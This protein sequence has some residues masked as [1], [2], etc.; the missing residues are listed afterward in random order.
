[1]ETAAGRDPLV[2]SGVRFEVLRV[3]S[4]EADN[5]VA[6][7]PSAA[8]R[9]GRAR[10]PSRL[11]RLAPPLPAP[12]TGSLPIAISR[13]HRSPGVPGCGS[14]YY[15][16][17]ISSCTAIPAI[18]KCSVH[19]TKG[20]LSAHREHQFLGRSLPPEVPPQPSTGCSWCPT[21]RNLNL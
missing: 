7:L 13:Q 20:W 19:P 17:D 9:V 10:L 21:C 2:K 16:L 11:T 14:T 15:N 6:A 4:S 5:D 8:P 18:A 1:M 3:F 12:S